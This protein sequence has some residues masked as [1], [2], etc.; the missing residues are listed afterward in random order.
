M[1]SP[2]YTELKSYVQKELDIEDETF[3]TANEILSYF[4][5]AVDMVEATIH[6]IYEDYFLTNSNI[7]LVNGTSTYSLPSDIYAQKIRG[8]LYDNGSDKKYEV[9]RLKKLNEIPFI[10]SNDYYRYIITNDST[11]GLKI[12]FYPTPSETSSTNLTLWYLRNAKKFSTGT[13]VCDIPEFTSV[14]VQYVRWKCHNK[15]GHPDT[16]QD[17]GLLEKMRQDMVETLT[18]RIPDE[19]NEIIKDMSFYADFDRTLDGGL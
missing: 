14:I 5:E 1:Y 15:E 4:N 18:G 10:D 6:T 12:K 11:N 13:D 8:F 17:Y 19:D 16:G 7:A 2:T 9:K 3:I